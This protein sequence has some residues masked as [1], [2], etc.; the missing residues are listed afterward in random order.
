MKRGNLNA[1]GYSA[2][3]EKRILDA[4]GRG[5]LKEFPN[6]GRSGCPGSNILKRIASKTM[7]LAEAEKWLNHLG[8]CSPCYKDFSGLRKGREVQ[9]RRTLLAVAASIL[10]AVGIASSVLVQ[11][12]NESLVAQT[13]VL[14]LRSRSVSR[15]PE[16]NPG[17]QPLELRRGFSQLNIYLP[18]GSPE[19]I[20]EV[21]IV[22]NSGKSLLNTGGT[23]QLNDG[24]TTLQVREDAYIAR[25]GQYILQI[26]KAPSEWNSYPL[27]LR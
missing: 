9:R 15:S 20:Y 19:G 8:S 5:L 18:L 24:I 4:L 10:V 11:R 13:A 14:D 12:H 3:D 25:P 22:T 17:E 27:V 6:P 21:R 16:P 2:A 1:R 23:A 26:R 7:P